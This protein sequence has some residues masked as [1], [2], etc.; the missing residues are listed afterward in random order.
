MEIAQKLP[1][2][3]EAEQSVLGAIIIDA[4]VLDSIVPILKNSDNFYAQSHKRIYDV[5]LAMHVA[6]K[7]IDFVTLLNEVKAAGIFSEEE[8]KQY[9]LQ[10]T[11]VVPS[12]ENAVN[13]AK[14]VADKAVLRQ[15]IAAADTIRSRSEEGAEESAMILEHAEQTIYDIANGRV[16]TGLYSINEGYMDAIERY[17]KLAEE[18]NT[19]LLG[20]PTSFAD[21][22]SMLN[23]G[24]RKSELIILAARPAVGKSAFAL[25]ICEHAAVRHGITT[26]FFSLEMSS[27]QLVDRV[28]ASQALVDNG[29]LM[30]GALDEKD[31]SNIAEAGKYLSTAPLYFDDTSD[32]TVSQMKAK[33]RR[34]KN[35]GLVVIDYLQLMNSGSK[36]ENRVQVVSEMTRALKLMA[37][38]LDVPVICLSQLSRKAADQGPDRKPKLSDLRES[39]SIEQDADIVIFLHNENQTSGDVEN[40][41][42]IEAIVGKNRRGRCGTAEL[43]WVGKHTKFF[44]LD[45]KHHDQSN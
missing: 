11:Q 1:F 5:M 6:N 12:T 33:L 26:V 32:V 29:K 35:L 39:G 4:S 3:F 19:A 42:V 31:W 37:K 17:G 10:L 18:D 34:V 30:T 2:S 22:D 44:N 27:A 15:L 23:G 38:E 24:M 13:Y 14:I 40:K 25:N 36:N 8:G 45:K 16:N 28:I 21:I 9:L 7:P 43:L 41:C 20:V